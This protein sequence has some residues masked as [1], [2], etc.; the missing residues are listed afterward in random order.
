MENTKKNR[1][2]NQFLL[3]VSSLLAVCSV[4]FPLLLIVVPAFTAA[5]FA[6]SKATLRT[7]A[8]V[9]VFPLIILFFLYAASEALLCTLP[10]L[11]MSIGSG[12]LIYTLQKNKFS[13]FDTVFYTA[14]LLG[15]MLY[16]SL[17]LPGLLSGK[18][19]FS[20]IKD[21]AQQIAASFKE[22]IS[23]LP[24]A[25]KDFL[26]QSV[27]SAGLESLPNLI[28]MSLVPCCCLISGALSF[29]NVLF[30]RLFIKKH[31]SELGLPPFRKFSLWNVPRS[32]IFGTGILLLGSIVLDFMESESADAVLLVSLS[33]FTFPLLIQ[34]LSLIDWFL[35]KGN[36]NI[37]KKRLLVYVLVG[38]LFRYTFTILVTLGVIEQFLRLR[39]RL[40]II[41]R[42]RGNST[43]GPFR[44]A[45]TKSE[46]TGSDADPQKN[47]TEE[48]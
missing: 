7:I 48:K 35:Q 36:G 6:R 39:E 18:G 40:V 37:R 22:A 32:Y 12:I 21:S 23:A 9:F 26:N 34:G 29:S 17:T 42:P 27:L 11:I 4:F 41:S 14:L 47:K 8:L 5:S 13:G 46:R 31:R 33:L 44:S 38:I 1:F 28:I 24:E 2:G 45:S 25:K 15:G 19:A 20:A 3:A 10:L 16:L 30:F 43:H